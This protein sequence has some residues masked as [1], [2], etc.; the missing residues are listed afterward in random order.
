MPFYLLTILFY[1]NVQAVKFYVMIPI[2]TNSFIPKN[3]WTVA[4]FSNY[5]P[6]KFSM[7]KDLNLRRL[8]PFKTDINIVRH[9]FK[10]NHNKLTCANTFQGKPTQRRQI[11]WTNRQGRIIRNALNDVRNE[12]NSHSSINKWNQV[13]L[14]LLLIRYRQ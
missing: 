4:T 12:G 13:L 1:Q 6:S 5:K 11:R 9:N 7:D 8:N 14:F 3:G 10:T 2:Y